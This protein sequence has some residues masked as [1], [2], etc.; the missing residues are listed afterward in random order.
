MCGQKEKFNL[1]RGRDQATTPNFA[2]ENQHGGIFFV[3]LRGFPETFRQSSN[4][5]SD[6]FTIGSRI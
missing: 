4:D 2:L 3:Q 5:T 6:L 1:S